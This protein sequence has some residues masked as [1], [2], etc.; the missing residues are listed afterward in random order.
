MRL[1]FAGLCAV[2]LVTGCAA[3]RP[4][5]PAPGP[6]RTF[7]GQ[8]RYAGGDRSFIGTFTA[9]VGGPGDFALDL[10]AG[11]GVPLLQIAVDGGKVT[12]RGPLSHGD[13]RR[14]AHWR[15]LGPK[16]HALPRGARTLDVVFEAPPESFAFRL[17]P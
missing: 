5:A 16:L 10:H 7:S 3:N 12:A 14:R 1:A 6:A 9:K 13:P 15:A 2:L 8:L 11:P 17:A 4:D